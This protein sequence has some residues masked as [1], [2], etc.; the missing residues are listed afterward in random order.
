MVDNSKLPYK[1]YCWVG[2]G[3]LSLVEESFILD[4]I[5]LI[6]RG[7][8]LLEH[9]ILNDV[10]NPLFLSAVIELLIITRSLLQK[11]LNIKEMP[12]DKHK[13]LEIIKYFRDGL[14]HTDSWR[15]KAGKTKYR[16]TYMRGNYDGT[17]PWINWN[18]G[19]LKIDKVSYQ[20]ADDICLYIGERGLWVNKNLI[21]IFKSI[22]DYFAKKIPSEYEFSVRCRR[23]SQYSTESNQQQQRPTGHHNKTQSD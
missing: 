11:Q 2:S 22:R 1:S 12:S 19:D 20:N 4:T 10:E 23:F 18:D 8:E 6:S 17:Q 13:D 9:G 14:C 3:D 7:E 15:S 16:I 21:S 5:T